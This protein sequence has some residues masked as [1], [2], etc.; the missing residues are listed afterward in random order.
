[1]Q[2]AK[3]GVNVGTIIVGGTAVF[4]VVM[5]S[6]VTEAVGVAVTIDPGMFV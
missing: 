6:G 2:A 1:L 5:I 4:V 3:F